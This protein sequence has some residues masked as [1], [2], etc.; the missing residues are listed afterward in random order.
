M[1]GIFRYIKMACINLYNFTMSQINIK[2]SFFNNI[3]NL[4]EYIYIQWN[5][6]FI[7]KLFQI[8]TSNFIRQIENSK[9]QILEFNQ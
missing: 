8:T 1:C 9:T 6:L 5:I 3:N 4:C 2:N 7:N